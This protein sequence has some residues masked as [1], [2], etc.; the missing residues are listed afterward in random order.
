MRR[1]TD[2]CLACHRACLE[3]VAYCLQQG[4]RH[5][6]TAHIRLLLD[7]AD[8]CATSADFMLRGSDL[9]GQTCTVCAEVCDRCARAGE[10][11]GDDA[12]MRACADACRRGAES[13]RRMAGGMAFT[14]AA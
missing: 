1:C 11:F 9:Y 10:Q 4:G 3:T 8:I 12:V 7:C 2:E 5:A 14:R 13:C 6:E